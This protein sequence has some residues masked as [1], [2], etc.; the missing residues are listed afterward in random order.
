M[1]ITRGEISGFLK[2]QV[3]AGVDIEAAKKAFKKWLDE[4]NEAVATKDEKLKIL[5]DLDSYKV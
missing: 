3:M 5:D 2:G 1:S 4:Q